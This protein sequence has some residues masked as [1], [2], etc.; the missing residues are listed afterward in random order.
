MTHGT[1][2][3]MYKVFMLQVGHVDFDMLLHHVGADPRME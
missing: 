3:I 2:R 1:S